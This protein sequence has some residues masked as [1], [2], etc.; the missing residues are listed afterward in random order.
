MHRSWLIGIVFI[1][2]LAPA[3]DFQSSWP[4]DLERVWPGPE[5]WSNPLQDWRVR[6][7]RLENIAAGGD[8]NVFLLTREIDARPGDLRMS[9][10]LGRLE[11][12]TAP[13]K[14]GFVG[15]RVGIRGAFR[16]YR[17]SAVR[18]FGLDAGLTADGRLFIA[19]LDGPVARINA[20]LQ[21]VELRLSAQPAG[22]NYRVALEALD[23]NGK[24]LAVLGR[25]DIPPRWLAGGL[26]L[27]SSSGPVEATPPPE[28]KI[29][30]P[31]WGGKRGTQRGG[32]LRFWFQDWKVS[33]AKVTAHDE[34]AFGPILFAMHTLDRRILKL[35]AQM[36]PVE[37]PS[38]EVL[39]QVKDGAGWRIIAKAA[40]DPLARTAT[41]RVSDW[42]DTKD[43]PY[44]VAYSMRGRDYH[45]EGTLRRDP[46]D[47]PEIVVAAFTGNNDLGFPHA[48]IV[49]NV[50]HFKPDFLAYTGDNIYERVGEYGIQ[51]QPLEAAVLDY[52]RKW[53]LFGWE[54]RELLKDIPSVSIPDDHDVYH[55]NLWGAGGRHAEGEGYKGQ[56]QGGY[57]MPAAF[58]N[59]VQRTQT[60]HLP[61]PFDPTPVEQGI[62]VYYCPLLYG[63]VSFAVIEDR[64]WKSAP[65][66]FLPKAKI[67]NGWAQDPGYDAARDG[68]APGAQLLGP[69]QNEFLNKWAADWS[70]GAWMKVVISQTLFANVATLPKDARGD[71]GTP[72]LKVMRPGEYAEGEAPVMDHDSN[73]W[74]RTG[75]N[76]ALRAMRRGFAFHIAGDQHLGS[77]IQYG[78]DD[79]ND[80]AWAICVPSVANVWPR[81]WFPPQ[82]GRNRK[83]G[84]PRYTGEFLEGF[85]NRITVHAVSN[86]VAAGAEPAALMDRAPGYGIVTF[87]RDT[88]K[89]TIANW[90]RWV[91]PS[92][93][94]AKPYDGWPLTIDQLDN[95]TPRGQ[96]ALEPITADAADPVVQV[97]DQSSG[98]TVYTLRIKGTSFTPRVFKDGLYTV[99]VNERVYR[100][101]KAR[102][103]P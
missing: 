65:R 86:P 98:E 91:D 95:G 11:E 69:R 99:K 34:R 74:P 79:W 43:T 28:E 45:Y 4:T 90:P 19:R 24:R 31:G 75:R 47:K 33:G 7:G 89:I 23:A 1:C 88:R 76:L 14:E 5:Y 56:D 68:D 44:R 3:A 37:K 22:V 15:F 9:V 42:D 66:E 12:D 51:R 53:L 21:N 38:G 85:G 29:G 78:I 70:G 103:G 48:D 16:D 57:T 49:R 92:K 27:V 26:A 39:L 67:V 59:A 10:K 61:D 55:G 30:D 93:P 50:S 32:T 18:G 20:P 35:T 40:I 60:S 36:A 102:P 94:G 83:P 41:F 82:P 54:Y 71:E 8:R 2:G 81:R 80:A 96:W 87:H 64:K 73:G 72:K 63:G 62:T 100:D 77:T 46:K 6:G 97:I 13:L 17:D 101:R 52:L 58:V 25:E 84:S